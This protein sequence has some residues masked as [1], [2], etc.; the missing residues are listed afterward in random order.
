[1]KTLR[2]LLMATA[3]LMMLA[4]PAMAQGGSEGD[5]ITKTFELT[6]NGEVPE[7][8]IFVLE[9]PYPSGQ[10]F[11]D[12]VFCGSADTGECLGGG[13]VYTTSV[14]A[15]AGSSE[16]FA[17]GRLPGG[18][19][20][21]IFHEGTVVA[22]DDKTISAEYTFGTGETPEEMPETGA[23]GLAPVAP[24]PVGNAV[25]GLAMLIGAGFAVLRRR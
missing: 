6:L 18:G 15:T 22:D 1:M 23:G 13:T 3:L 19:S 12:I 11:G 21:E 24:I 8:D 4:I 16:R 5:T 20:A 10:S 7:G 17:F 9:Y 14:E 25:A 2:S